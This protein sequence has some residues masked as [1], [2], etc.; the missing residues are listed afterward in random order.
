[1]N[2]PVDSTY[3]ANMRLMMMVVMLCVAGWLFWV[4]LLLMDSVGFSFLL[5][6]SLS[7]CSYFSPVPF[8]LDHLPLG[9]CF[10]HLWLVLNTHTN[11]NQRKMLDEGGFSLICWHQLHFPSSQRPS[12]WGEKENADNEG[13]V[14][15]PLTS[16]TLLLMSSTHICIPESS[17]EPLSPTLPFPPE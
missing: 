8:V 12:C 14:M 4:L 2:Q 1:M 11:I 3:Y 13:K 6:W 17:T 5:G 10:D 9:L 16:S 7:F 15:P